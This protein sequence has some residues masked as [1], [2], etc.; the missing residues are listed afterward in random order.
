MKPWVLGDGEMASY[1][2][3]KLKKR[4]CVHGSHTVHDPFWIFDVNSS[5]H[6]FGFNLRTLTGFFFLCVYVAVQFGSDM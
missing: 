6:L 4:L 1:I 2:V 5:P 3:R